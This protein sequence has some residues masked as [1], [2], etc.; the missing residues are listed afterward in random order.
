MGC[1]ITKESRIERENHKLS[2]HGVPTSNKKIIDSVIRRE[3][4]DLSEAELERF[5]EAIKT[6]MRNDEKP[7]T[8]IFFKIAGKPGWPDYHYTSGIDTFP[9]WHRLLLVE[10]E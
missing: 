10:F 7:G 2:S 8:S 5:V 4:N 3:I 6:M 9:M 1:G